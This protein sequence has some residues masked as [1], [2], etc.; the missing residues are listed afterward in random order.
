MAPHFYRILKGPDIGDVV[1]SIRALEAFAREHGP[2]RY[3][4]DEYAL[5]PFP[6][7]NLTAR[8]WGSVIHQEDGHIVLDAIDWSGTPE[9]T[10][11]L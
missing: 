4:V 1:D 11:G 2:G 10:A 7:S 8:I 5:E 3:H 6:G 9:A